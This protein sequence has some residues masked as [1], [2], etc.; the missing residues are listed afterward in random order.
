[1]VKRGF[2]FSH[3]FSS[4]LFNNSLTKYLL[5]SMSSGWDT[6]HAF[7]WHILIKCSALMYWHDTGVSRTGIV[8]VLWGWWW[9]GG[10]T[11]MK[12]STNKHRITKPWGRCYGRITGGISFF[13]GGQR[14]LPW[15]GGTEADQLDEKEPFTGTLGSGKSTVGLRPWGGKECGL[16]EGLKSSEAGWG[17]GSQ[18][19]DTGQPPSPCEGQQKAS[20]GSGLRRRMTP[21][22]MYFYKITL[23]TQCGE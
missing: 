16:C 10:H 9:W 5:I 12:S 22:N 11:L 20:S 7:P 23:A 18:V 3:L 21:S 1:M 6:V 4:H 15:E 8:W 14:G 17:E 19:G 2:P 13:L